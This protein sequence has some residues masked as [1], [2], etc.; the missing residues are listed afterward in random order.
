[1]AL[2]GGALACGSENAFKKTVDAFYEQVH[3]AWT[4]HRIQR[5]VFLDHMGCGAYKVE[6]NGGCDFTPPSKEYDYHLQVKDHVIAE[7]PVR[8]RAMGLPPI[9]LDFWIF[10]NPDA[11]VAR[12]LEPIKLHK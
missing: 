11:P 1:V 12:P 3:A 7:F 6:F 5:V 10:M 9:G 4:L 8:T 2:A